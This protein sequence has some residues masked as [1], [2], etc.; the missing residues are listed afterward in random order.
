MSVGIGILGR[1]PFVYTAERA[2][3]LIV[4][5]GLGTKTSQA[6][7]EWDRITGETYVLLYGHSANRENGAKY[8]IGRLHVPAALDEQ[9]TKYGP[10]LTIV[11]NDLLTD[12]FPGS[13]DPSGQ[14]EANGFDE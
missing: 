14:E 13:S 12:H 1:L 11:Q 3:F 7:V 5:P 2:G 8:R 10:G 6:Y 4:E 9:L